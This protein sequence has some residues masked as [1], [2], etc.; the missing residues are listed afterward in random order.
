MKSIYKFA[1]AIFITISLSNINLEH[2]QTQAYSSKSNTPSNEFLDY[3]A[4]ITDE[5]RK[6]QILFFQQALDEL[7]ATSPEQVVKIWAKAELTRN[8]IFHYA[9]ACDELKS[10]LIRKWGNPE[11]NF[12]N[13]GASSPWLDKYEIISNKKLSVSAFEVKIKFYWATSYTPIETTETTL[14]IIKNGNIWCVK[15]VK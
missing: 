14:T 3:Y 11:E 1:T 2:F 5:Q 8:G 10:D 9:V 4:N 7:G 15:E 6:S 13:I 12:W